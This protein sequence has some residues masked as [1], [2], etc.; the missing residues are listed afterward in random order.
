MSNGN[1]RI[2]TSEI[3]DRKPPC[4]SEAE[5]GVVGS[6]FLDSSFYD[7]VAFLRPSDFH[8]SRLA[9]LFAH[10]SALCREG[11]ADVTLLLARLR[12]AGELEKAGGAA[13]VYEIGRSV[14]GRHHRLQGSDVD[15][16]QIGQVAQHA[17][18][19]A[20]IVQ[21]RSKK[22][23][24]IRSATETLRK[25]YADEGT[26]DDLIRQMRAD[27]EQLESGIVIADR[28]P[29]ITAAQLSVQTIETPYL[30]DG[31]LAANQPGIL[32]GPKKAGKTS[33]ALDMGI[34]LST[35]GYFLG[36]FKVP[37]ATRTAVMTG[38][39]GLATIQDTIR[40]IADAA[41]KVPADL[42]NLL[43]TE[44]LPRIGNMDDM[45]ALER[46]LLDNELLVL[47]ID[48]SY[49]AMPGD[50]T[51]NLHV[52]GERLRSLN[53][54]CRRTGCTLILLHHTTKTL[55][56]VDPFDPPELE[57]IAWAGY[58]EW[59]R[60]WLLIGR[61]EQYQPGSG[62][63][64][65]WLSV[66]G[67]A[68]HSGRWGVDIDEGQF[69]GPGSRIWNVEVLSVRDAQ[70]E[71]REREQ[72]TKG[73]TRDEDLQARIEADSQT[74]TKT[75]A[76]F[77]KGETKSIIRDTSGLHTSRFNVAFGALLQ[78]GDVVPCDVVK[79]NRS[80]PYEGY[81]LAEG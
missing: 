67:S 80:K 35:G 14:A 22:R 20:G 76:K 26:A 60:Q 5:T 61:R 32:A 49:L 24:A 47:M 6:L 57:H 29:A 30:I 34:A 45:L 38:E 7:A 64:R 52:V 77:P 10:Y 4:D 69:N 51:A 19:Y 12:E 66:G 1:G 65:L 79:G 53:D 70:A 72:D 40:R 58:Q 17:K 28:F 3:L 55:R 48:P 11:A 43:I 31:V 78:A 41:G 15:S 59:A 71:A 36:K 81:Q 25:A 46:F 23:A 18:H 8:D 74:I 54:V 16:I 44:E 21:D 13:F 33:L 27:A 62:I 75:L 68:G 50:D 73:K 37:T 42:D 2:A 56:G 63:H 39:S 9:K